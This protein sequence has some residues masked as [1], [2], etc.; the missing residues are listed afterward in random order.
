[1]NGNGK[2]PALWDKF[3]EGQRVIVVAVDRANPARTHYL[4]GVIAVR[5]NHLWRRRTADDSTTTIENLWVDVGA[6]SRAEVR[7]MG[8]D[9]LDPVVRDWPE[10]TFSDL[11]AGPAAGNR[12]GCAAVAAASANE[13]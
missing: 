13:A 12:A 10:W 7:K 6:R 1:M 8:I 3:H 11:V 2:H 5:S 9:L 4:P